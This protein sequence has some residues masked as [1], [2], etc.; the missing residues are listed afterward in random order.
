[1]C[2]EQ[3]KGDFGK[4]EGGDGGLL[5]PPP[6]P[7]SGGDPGPGSWA[8]GAAR[9]S[10]GVPGGGA[11]GAGGRAAGEEGP[12]GWR[13]E[14]G[15]VGGA[16]REPGEEVGAG[17]NSAAP[18]RAGKH[19]PGPRAEG[20][21]EGPC[22]PTSPPRPPGVLAIPDPAGVGGWG[23]GCLEPGPTFLGSAP[24][25]ARAPLPPSFLARPFNPAKQSRWKKRAAPRPS[26]LFHLKFPRHRTYYYILPPTN[27]EAGSRG[28][29]GGG[30]GGSAG[31]GRGGRGR[32]GARLARGRATRD[33]FLERTRSSRGR[34]SALPG[35]GRGDE[36]R[37]Y[38]R[39]S[40]PACMVLIDPSVTPPGTHLQ[41]RRS[42]AAAGF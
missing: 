37:G 38:A 20:E 12:G 7:P 31:G 32:P 34:T 42:G 16:G 24:R 4:A 22:L 39:H 17:E 11:A 21:G 14:E 15:R 25:G 41:R 29:G 9:R 33:E 1:M 27:R 40:S 23:W 35:L 10:S 28:P 36:M 30:G 2:T 18:R 3:E 5:P 19:R 6:H 26:L 13:R 8:R